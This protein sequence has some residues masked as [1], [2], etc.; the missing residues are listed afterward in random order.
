MPSSVNQSKSATSVG[1]NIN[2]A[3]TDI[4]GLLVNDVGTNKKILCIS[5]KLVDEVL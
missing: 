4:F 3:S 5:F 1:T 2:N